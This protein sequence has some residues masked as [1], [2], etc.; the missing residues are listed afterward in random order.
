MA[1]KTKMPH[2]CKHY[3]SVVRQCKCLKYLLL[4]NHIY[5]VYPQMNVPCTGVVGHSEHGIPHCARVAT[6]SEPF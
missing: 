4:E 6:N 2:C 1:N 3:V 5:A